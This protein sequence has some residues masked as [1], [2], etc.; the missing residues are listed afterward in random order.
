MKE[1]GERLQELREQ[2]GLT[3]LQ[4]AKATGFTEVSIGRW[5]K[6]ETIPDIRTLK[7]FVKFFNV[8]ADYLLGLSD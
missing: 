5:E 3:R 6:A 1:F 8:T 4:L 2:R 7:V